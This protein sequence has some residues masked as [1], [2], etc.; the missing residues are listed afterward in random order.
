M[1]SATV[2]VLNDGQIHKLSI[3]NGSLPI[4]FFTILQGWHD[5]GDLS[6]FFLS[7][8]SDNPF[9]AYFL[10]LPPLKRA[11]LERPFECVFVNSPALA[12]V[13]ADIE[14]FS[15]YFLP[16]TTVVDFSNLGGDAR[17]VT[18]CPLAVNVDYTHLAVFSRM[19]SSAQ[20][21][22]LWQRV[23]GLVDK[24]LNDQPLWLSTSG[25]G[26]SWLHIRIDRVPKYYSYQ[27]YRTPGG[28]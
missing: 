2:D 15:T 24:N 27:A 25:L 8:L 3:F 11:D 4:S 23:A 12:T 13:R 14:A 10:E 26:V 20:Q 7:C 28:W 17:L 22:A 16:D 19:A 21:L 1:L 9:S 6:R 5:A 18:P